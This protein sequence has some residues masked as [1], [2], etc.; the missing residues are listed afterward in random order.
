MPGIILYLNFMAASERLWRMPLAPQATFK[1]PDL[2]NFT[3]F[4]IDGPNI[5]AG[6]SNVFYFNRMAYEVEGLVAALIYDESTLVIASEYGRL[7]TFYNI[8]YPSK[9]SP[10]L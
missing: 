8:I 1:Y 4:D 7:V 2:M 9:E 5:F 6:N 3:V 10:Y